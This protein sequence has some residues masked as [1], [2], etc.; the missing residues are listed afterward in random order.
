MD[1]DVCVCMLFIS[2]C[3]QHDAPALHVLYTLYTSPHYPTF[4]SNPCCHKK[5]MQLDI[6]APGDAL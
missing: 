6:R 2:A 3:V 5:Y 4:S 1:K